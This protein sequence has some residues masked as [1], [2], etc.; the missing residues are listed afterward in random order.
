MIGDLD[1]ALRIAAAGIL[2]GIIGYERQAR[3]K[4]AGLRT[5]ILVSMGSCLIMILSINIYGTVEGLTNADPARLAAQVVS[6]IGFLGAGSIMKEGLTV[7]GL[8]TAASLW[9]VSGVGL[10]VGSGYYLAAVVTTALV[11]IT[12]TVLT[13]VEHRVCT[14]DT[15]TLAVTA[16]NQPGQLGSIC[17]VLGQYG[18]SI[19]DV[20]IEEHD[21][22]VIILAIK[23]PPDRSVPDT[24]ASILGVSGV[25]EVRREC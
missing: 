12:L 10:A 19:V 11:F 20:K 23:L 1:I 4:S 15:V 8:T 7:R 3:H 24:I 22:L 2:G 9:V 14:I 18:I 16:A 13:K 25:I 5:H 17:S 6:G 21:P